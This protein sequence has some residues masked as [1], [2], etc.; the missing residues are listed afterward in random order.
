VDGELTFESSHDHARMVDARVWALRDRVTLIHDEGL[1]TAKPPRQAIVEIGLR[2]GRVQRHHA[3]AVRG[4][5]DNP[6]AFDEVARK[7]QDL[8]APVLGRERSRQVIERC[9]ELD[10]LADAGELARLLSASRAS[11]HEL[12]HAGRVP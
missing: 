4:T 6:M 9:R 11:Q 12:R 10:T 2:D 1:M 5:P 7:A 3:R 8:M